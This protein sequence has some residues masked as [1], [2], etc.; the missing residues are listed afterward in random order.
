MS[1]T[2]AVISTVFNENG[3]FVLQAGTKLVLN[4]QL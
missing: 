4:D 2:P 3:K 1:L